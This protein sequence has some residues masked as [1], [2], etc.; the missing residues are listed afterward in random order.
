MTALQIITLV[1]GSVLVVGGLAVIVARETTS[2]P[3]RSIEPRSR[4]MIEVLLP[5]LG[6]ALLLGALWAGVR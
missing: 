3:W 6:V 2:E 5:V 4:Q 1:V